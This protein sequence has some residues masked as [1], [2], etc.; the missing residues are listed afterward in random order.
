MLLFCADAMLF[1]KKKK[2]LTFFAHEN[3]KKLTS[4]VAYIWQ[5]GVFSLLFL[6]PKIAQD[7]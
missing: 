3:I 5:F 4:K 7:W 6:L 2:I 1:S